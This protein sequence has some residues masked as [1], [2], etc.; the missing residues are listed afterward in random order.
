VVVP[1]G[2]NTIVEV[3]AGDVMPTSLG[4]DDACAAGVVAGPDDVASCE[5]INGLVS[6]E[7][8]KFS[9]VCANEVSGC[10]QSDEVGK[11]AFELLLLVG[12]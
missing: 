8:N 1:S 7:D 12:T 11:N 5:I 6:D 10:C 4:N 2:L 9:N 3:I